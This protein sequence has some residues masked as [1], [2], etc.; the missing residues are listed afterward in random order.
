MI[1][2]FLLHVDKDCAF[3][4]NAK[5]GTLNHNTEVY[6]ATSE[7]TTIEAIKANLEVFFDDNFKISS[8]KID[9]KFYWVRVES[10]PNI[11]FDL[12]ISRFFPD[13]LDWK[14]RLKQMGI[15]V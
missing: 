11:I 8:E 9:T 1:Q 7:A 14:N 3:K 6:F 2:E 15:N 4:I 5:I 10:K 12:S 13:D